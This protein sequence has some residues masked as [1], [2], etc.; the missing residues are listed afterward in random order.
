[1]NKEKEKSIRKERLSF[2]T[3]L[4]V[5]TL[6]VVFLNT[7]IFGL[8]SVVGPSMEDTLH[9]EERLIVD[10]ISYNFTDPSYG[11]IIVFLK[12]EKINGFGGRLKIYF[13]DFSMKF[14][15]ENRKNRLIKRVVGLPGDTIDI[16]SNEVYRNNL[17]IT[18][19]YIK[20]ITY[21]N[22]YDFPL[23]V[24][25]DKIFVLGDNRE[26]SNDS[27]AFGLVDFKSIEGKALMRYWPIK[28]IK[29]LND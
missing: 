3:H 1:M 22:Q 7:G 29:F 10:K 19:K 17:K 26:N 9:N 12:N 23:T 14:K 20:G 28:D 16:R 11:D 21:I 18:E 27:R 24:P 8:T 4:I 5:L 15:G 2:L 6:L 25:K 13:G